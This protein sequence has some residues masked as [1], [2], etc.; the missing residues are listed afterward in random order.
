MRSKNFISVQNQ[1]FIIFGI[2]WAEDREVT[3]PYSSLQFSIG[4]PDFSATSEVTGILNETE[5]PRRP[6][7]SATSRNSFTY[8]NG[9]LSLPELKY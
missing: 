1:K 4:R 5:I 6:A 8:E 2:V 7:F 9:P 3:L